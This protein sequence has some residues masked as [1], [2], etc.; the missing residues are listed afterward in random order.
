MLGVNEKLAY[1]FGITWNELVKFQ[2]QLK[3]HYK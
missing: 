2:D 3:R 1:T